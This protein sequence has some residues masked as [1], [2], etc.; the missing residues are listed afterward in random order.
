MKNIRK[1]SS[2]FMLKT[3]GRPNRPKTLTHFAKRGRIRKKG[4]KGFGVADVA[5]SDSRLI[6][7]TL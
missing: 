6:P 3:Y 4:E 2:S 1:S 5:V 7:V